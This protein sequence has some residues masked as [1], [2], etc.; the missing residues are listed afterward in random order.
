[1]EIALVVLV[2]G[3]HQLAE[4]L[5]GVAHQC[6]LVEFPLLLNVIEVGVIEAAIDG[7]GLVV[8]D[9]AVAVELVDEPVALVGQLVVGVV[10]FA[11]PV[12]VVVLPCSIIVR[13]F[14][15]IELAFAISHVLHFFPFVATAVLILLDYV[16]SLLVFWF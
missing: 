5:F 8:V 12:H 14:L 3:Q 7:A 9:L 13:A 11:E 4:A 1:M 15:V 2:I 6:P 10:Q 16:L